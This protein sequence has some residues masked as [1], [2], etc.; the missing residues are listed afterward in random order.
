MPRQISRKAA[1][2]DTCA[3]VW[4]GDVLYGYGGPGLNKELAMKHGTGSINRLTKE[5]KNVKYI[6]AFDKKL[7]AKELVA[8]AKSLVAEEWTPKAASELMLEQVKKQ[9]KAF[10]LDRIYDASGS[11]AACHFDGFGGGF[12]I[13]FEQEPE[14]VS[15]TISISGESN[16]KIDKVLDEHFDNM[17]FDDKNDLKNSIHSTF[18]K[19]SEVVSELY[20][21]DEE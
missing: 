14:G 13:W 4:S 10:H 12:T 19:L 2:E 21:S 6:A 9:A 11:H 8:I 18:Q 7:V 17:V 3:V 15:S 5:N 1:S 16:S 20:P